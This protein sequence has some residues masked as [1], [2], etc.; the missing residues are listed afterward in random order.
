MLD[1]NKSAET[2]T[3][4]VLHALEQCCEEGWFDTSEAERSA[5]IETLS[6]IMNTGGR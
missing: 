5:G 1:E 2:M 3:A 6:G 4:V